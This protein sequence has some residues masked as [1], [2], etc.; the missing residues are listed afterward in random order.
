MSSAFS[1]NF[2]GSSR[3]S[4]FEC[5]CNKTPSAD[6]TTRR[7]EQPHICCHLSQHRE[8][9][10]YGGTSSSHTQI[11]RSLTL[12]AP[13]ALKKQS[14]TEVCSSIHATSVR[15]LWPL[16]SPETGVS[17][18]RFLADRLQVLSNSSLHGWATPLRI[19]GP[20]VRE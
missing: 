4:R 12:D 19:L 6:S 9:F 13:L 10:L 7:W 1:R 20:P 5:Y 3:P 11:P 16:P 14:H 17:L 18:Q 2:C 15:F 8:V